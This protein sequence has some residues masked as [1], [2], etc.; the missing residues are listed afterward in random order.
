[1]APSVTSGILFRGKRE[2][3]WGTA[4]TG[5]YQLFNIDG[6]TLTPNSEGKRSNAIRSD[7]QTVNIRRTDGDG[8]GPVNT[9]FRYGEWDQWFRSVMNSADWNASPGTTGAQNDLTV[10]AKSGAVPGYFENAGSVNFTALFFPGQWVNSLGFDDASNNDRRKVLSVTSTRLYVTGYPALIGDATA[11]TGSIITA[12]AEVTNGTTVSSWSLEREDETASEFH[13]YLGMSIANVAIEMPTADFIT[14][15]WEWTGKLPSAGA[16]SSLETTTSTAAS[17]GEPMISAEIY[18]VL[19]GDPD[20]GD[21]TA[22]AHLYDVAPFKALGGT[23]RIDP[24]LTPRKGWG[25]VGPFA[26]PGRGDMLVSGTIRLLYNADGSRD[27]E[28]LFDKIANETVSAL[29]IFI[30]D[31]VNSGYIIDIPRLK[32]TGGRR[33]A[34]AKSQ[35]TVLEMNF[36]GYMNPLDYNYSRTAETATTTLGTTVRLARF[37]AA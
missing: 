17:T 28:T 2:T 9:E 31:P 19:E 11:A 36:E 12:L 22:N 13:Q 34:P 3:T 37:S 30:K 16:A 29:S 14:L 25:T 1:M 21:I 10:V 18:R 26:E 32:F 35:D 33:N 7:G 4:A 5:V 8:G 15:V 6:E 27:D 20:L 24:S 23:V